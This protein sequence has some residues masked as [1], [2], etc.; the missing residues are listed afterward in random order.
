MG[1]S[2]R[3]GAPAD[4]TSK[5]QDPGGA[6][7][8]QTELLWTGGLAL[9]LLVFFLGLFVARGF[10]FP[11]GPD[12][13]V[14]LWWTRLAQVEGLSAVERPGVP[15]VVLALS[16][17]LHLPIAAVAA[18]LQCGLGVTLGLSAAMLLR[19]RD[20]NDR[21]TWLLGGTLAG[22]F[23][24]HLV[25]GYLANLALAATFLAAAVVLALGTRRG[26]LAAG[27]LLAAGGFAHPQFFLV[28]LAILGLA[29]AFAAR[30]PRARSSEAA[31]TGED[32]EAAHGG[33]SR[34]AVRTGQALLAAVGVAGAG[35]LALRL[36]GPG[37]LY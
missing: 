24:V 35:F 6:L 36:R 21:A 1:Y 10:R 23:A 34:E 5:D 14:Y 8:S 2:R 27:A 22:L 15:A 7:A 19:A 28:A 4:Q 30:G 33:I 11:V 18:A 25:S 37:V 31:R 17:T 3:I 9:L 13:P 16:G 12:G 26:A 20:A 32:S 29:A